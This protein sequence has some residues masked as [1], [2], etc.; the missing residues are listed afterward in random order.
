M[1]VFVIRITDNATGRG[2][3]I[4]FFVSDQKAVIRME[5]DKAKMAEVFLEL[6]DNADGL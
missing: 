5:K 4:V 3:Q 1:Y 2:Y 6:D